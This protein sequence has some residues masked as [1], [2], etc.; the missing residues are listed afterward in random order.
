MK[1]LKLSGILLLI[2]SCF[3]FQ[4][5]F[6][7]NQK[8][9]SYLDKIGKEDQL[10]GNI[11]L[12]VKGQIIAGR[13][14][15]YAD[16]EAC[17]PN[18]SDFRFNIASISKVFTSTA[19]LQLRDKK[20][21]SLDDHLTKFFPD[22]PFAG[23]TIRHLLTHTS[24]LPDFALYDNIAKLNPGMVITNKDI[25]PEL[26]NWRQGLGFNPGENYQ[27]CNVGYNLLAMVIE[28]VSGLSLSTYLKRYIF[29]PAGMNNTYLSIYPS[30]FFY[31]DNLCVK[32]HYRPHPYY[33]TIYKH[34]DSSALF[35]YMKF[36]NYTCS[37]LVGGSNIISTTTDLFKFDLAFFDGRLLKHSTIREAIT[38]MK[39]NNGE[40][41]FDKQMDTM[42]GDGKMAV[43][44]GW[45]I[46]EQPKYG[47]SVGHGGFLFGNATF[48]FHNP[49]KKQ[50]II[51][52][53]NTAGSEF[54][55][56]VT[57]ALNLLNGEEPM[58]IR[59]HQSMAFLYGSTLVKH[60]PDA[61][62]CALNVVKDDTA[63]YYL[64][65]WEF[66]QLGGNLLYRSA[67]DGHQN[68]ALEVFK[69]CTL[70]FPHS[71]NTYDSYAEGLIVT[72]RKQEAI[73]MYR[74]SISLNPENEYGKKSLE[75]LLKN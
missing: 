67:F 22:F 2:I 40:I 35:E 68:M 52:F 17:I 21:L 13:S 34:A 64:S 19:I 4:L 66:N 18:T 5:S 31:R 73:Q 26:K 56:I 44:L 16:F 69:I 57:S 45:D 32:M 74:K 65:E 50:T 36:A 53:D 7:Q 46:F 23:I 37:G 60:G 11:L 24:G 47:K 48:Y 55:R 51:A 63:H 25:I 9:E 29:N 20:K 41:F 14:F 58:A 30:H 62:A 27:Y 38:P 54:G 6:G 71:Y 49:E 42:L 75:E 70:L 59:N 61:A 12:A 72:G 8:I 10:N 1:P 39:L 28:K 3:C 43:G 33:D 15:G